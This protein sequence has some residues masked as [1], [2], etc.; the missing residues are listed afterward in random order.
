MYSLEKRFN[1]LHTVWDRETAILSN[2]NTIVSHPAY[3]EII[4]MGWEA[5]PLI[6]DRMR[7][8]PDH[9][10]YALVKI[11][12]E[13]HA[14]GATTVD[15][16]SQRWVN[17]YDTR[18]FTVEKLD[19]LTADTKGIRQTYFKGWR[20]TDSEGALWDWFWRNQNTIRSMM[21]KSP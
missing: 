9:W 17:W 15:E 6:I 5:V 14:A 4:G 11:T 13:D 18:D 8:D 19:K 20:L 12:G 10:F 3:Q 2:V 16:A 7:T 1:E 21:E